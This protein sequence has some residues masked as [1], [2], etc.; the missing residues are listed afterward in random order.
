VNTAFIAVEGVL[1]EHSTLHGFAPIPD[2]IKLATALRSLYRLVLGTSQPRAEAVEQ[3]LT[4]NGLVTPSFYGQLL[5]RQGPLMDAEG[6]DLY[7]GYASLLRAGG[8]DVGLV[9]ASDPETILRATELG[10]PCLLF[11]NPAYRWSEYRPDRKRLPRP[12]QDIEDEVVRQKEL[13]AT[14]S[15]LHEYEGE[16]A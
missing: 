4:I 15:R 8:A 9:V 2:G 13:K 7:S 10:F 3:W 11:V 1:G 5:H 12:W 14:D 16:T 6:P